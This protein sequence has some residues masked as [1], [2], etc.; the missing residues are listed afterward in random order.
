MKK[1]CSLIIVLSLMVFSV[2]CSGSKQDSGAYNLMFMPKLTGIPYFNACHKGAEEAA[3]ELNIN[4][5]YDG[6]TKAD[7]NQQIELLEQWTASGSYQAF[8]V[9]CNDPNRVANALK[10]AKDKGITVV[11]YDADC[12]T[13]ARSYFVNMATY[14]AVAEEMVEV[15]AEQLAPKVEGKI[16]ILTSSIEA[17][18]Q[19]QW[20]DRIKAYAKKK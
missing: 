5:S 13:E 4:L 1:L 3:K 17:P 15:L 8:A 2:G 6:A 9:A 12:K 10:D 18:N 16:G 14:D 11:T 7:S 20:A 19:R